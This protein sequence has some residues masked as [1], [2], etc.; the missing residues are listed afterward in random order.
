MIAVANAY[1]VRAETMAADEKGTRP[2]SRT[3]MNGSFVRSARAIARTVAATA[4]TVSTIVS[5]TGSRPVSGT[6][7]APNSVR[8]Y[9][10]GRERDPEERRPRQVDPA[11]AAWRVPVPRGRPA[12]DQGHDA[13]RHVDEEDPPPGRGEERLER[14]AGQDR[15]RMEAAQHRRPDERPGGHPEERQR[16][17]DPERAGARA[18][19]EEVRGGRGP[20]RDEGAAADRLDEAR[21]DE[22]VQGL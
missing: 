22:L 10:P 4:T 15:L 3:S 13:D 12:D 17:D 2:N 9:E 11:G 19:A 16:A 7:V 5:V 18:A 8:A 14:L 20:H 1:P 6:L 21:R